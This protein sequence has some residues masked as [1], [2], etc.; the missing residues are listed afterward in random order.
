MKDSRQHPAQDRA[1]CTHT[2]R[3][4]RFLDLR[5]IGA[6]GR[7]PFPAKSGIKSCG[8]RFQAAL[9]FFLFVFS[10]ASR[11]LWRGGGD[12]V[13][14]RNRYAGWH[15]GVSAR[16]AG[17][18][19]LSEAGTV[20]RKSTRWPKTGPISCCPSIWC[21]LFCGGAS[22]HAVKLAGDAGARRIP[23]QVHRCPMPVFRAH[24]RCMPTS[25]C[26][27]RSRCCFSQLI[28]SGLTTRIW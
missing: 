18:C 11:F 13:K 12:Q 20:G 5:P 7:F 14:V 15:S 24:T 28:K 23:L 27:R 16:E 25:H 6:P 22:C 4:P 17:P 10:M 19:S 8:F 1:C 21:D 26:C 3:H 2:A 9:A